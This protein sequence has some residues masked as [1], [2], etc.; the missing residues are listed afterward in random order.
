M[1]VA[2]FFSLSYNEDNEAFWLQNP[3][4]KDT[5]AFIENVMM[6]RVVK[7]KTLHKYTWT[8]VKSDLE[9]EFRNF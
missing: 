7:K 5:I 2:K 3:C 1:L 9:S 8:C 4:H 6:F